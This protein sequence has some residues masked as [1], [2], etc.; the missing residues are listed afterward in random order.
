MSLATDILGTSKSTDISSADYTLLDDI[1]SYNAIWL[2][3]AIELSN[4]PILSQFEL[5]KNVPLPLIGLAYKPVGEIEFLS[6]EWS[7]YP[8]LSK[9]IITNAGIKQATRF[10]LDVY[11]VLNGSNPV[12][13]NLLK[14]SAIIKFLD[15]YI[16]KGGLFTV[17]TLY[18]FITDCVLEKITGISDGEMLDG[19]HLRF[20]F[21]KPNIDTTVIVAKQV[22]DLVN[23][24]NLGGAQTLGPAF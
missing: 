20:N 2:Q 21:L 3:N 17:L 18:G 8:Y 11:S 5:T 19:T 9:Q 10:A 24:I 7:Q 14:V 1:F 6:Y 12:A 13:L 23:K 16:A 15:G 4:I 22:S